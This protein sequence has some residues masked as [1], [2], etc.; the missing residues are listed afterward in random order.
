MNTCSTCTWW[1]IPSGSK[2][3]PDETLPYPCCNEDL[4]AFSQDDAGL[5]I[6]RGVMT[7]AKFGCVQH[8]PIE[9]QGVQEQ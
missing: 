2:G 3:T 4:N 5:V 9:K 7:Y 6:F 8:Q 1:G